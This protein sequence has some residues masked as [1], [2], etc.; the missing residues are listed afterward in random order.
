M[1]LNGYE[2]SKTLVQ[3]LGVGAC[4]EHRRQSAHQWRFPLPFHWET[5]DFLKFPREH[6]RLQKDNTGTMGI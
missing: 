5:F 6:P 2:K 4:A 3:A 1:L